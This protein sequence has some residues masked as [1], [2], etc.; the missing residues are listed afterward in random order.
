MRE[1]VFDTNIW[2]SYALGK[3]LNSLIEVLKKS[4]RKIISSPELLNEI[5]NSIRKLQVRKYLSSNR[6]LQ[7]LR[8][9]GAFTTEVSIT[10]QGAKSIDVKD[11]YL[12]NLCLQE[13]IEFLVTGDK[14]LLS[15]KFYGGTKIINYNAY[16]KIILEE[17]ADLHYKEFLPSGI[18]IT[19]MKPEHT[20]QLE[21]LQRIVFPSLAENELL[22]ADQYKKHLEIFPKGQFVAVD[23]S[24]VIGATTTMRYHYNFT[25]PEYHTFFE[26]MGGGWLT[27]HEPDGEWLYGIDVSVDP[28]YR[29]RG[30][31]KALYRARQHTCKVLNL[32]GQLTVGMLNGYEKVKKEMSVE[33]YYEKVKQGEMFD[34]TV[35]VQKKVGFEI[36]GLMKDYLND[37]TCGNAGAVIV[38]A[39]DKKIE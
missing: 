5:K 21:A 2:I 4:D 24:K 22:H 14:D 18:L 23:G 25:K 3:R 26:V 32:K 9:L 19:E 35:S 37:P 39:A 34:P 16:L 8:L 10:T 29:N 1:I 30:I 36:V 7:L 33:E 12:L 31:A 20:S 15:L 27:T 38:L 6:Y 13:K 28:H 11:D 17:I